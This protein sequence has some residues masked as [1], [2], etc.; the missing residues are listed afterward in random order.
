MKQEEL[1]ALMHLHGQPI[2]LD[3]LVRDGV[4]TKGGAW[5]EVPDM[6]KLPEPVRARI[7]E[8]SIRNGRTFIKLRRVSKA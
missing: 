2:D 7:R 5:W 6:S 4:L 1:D 8:L 3:A